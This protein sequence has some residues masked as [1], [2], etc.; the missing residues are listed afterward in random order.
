[1]FINNS[2]TI[3]DSSGGEG[4]RGPVYSSSGGGDGGRN[5]LYLQKFIY[6]S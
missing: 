6:F 1:M 3:P 4:G 2:K 5:F